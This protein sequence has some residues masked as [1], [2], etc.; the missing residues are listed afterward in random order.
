MT[1]RRRY[2]PA[3]GWD[4]ALP[5]YDPHAKLLGWDAVRSTLLE[6]MA[7]TPGQRV[8]DIGCATGTLLVH[9][10]Q[11]HPDVAVVGLDPDPKALA[12]AAR[13]ALRAGVKVHFNRGFSDQL[14]YA[15]ASFDH[16]SCT[17]MFSLL[18]PAE[19][20]TTLREIRR[21]LRPGGSFHLLDLVKNPPGSS[22][23]VRF[24]PQSARRFHA[25]TED[26]ILALMGQAGLTGA[27]RTRQHPFWLWPLAS[28]RASR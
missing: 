9:L 18:P 3:A 6:Q 17:G 15:N 23:W 8:L 27:R 21:V 25:C 2:F 5:I 10:K 4:W 24:L 19:K 26:E 7:L 22:L 14:P 20:E 28:Y 16:V 13:K 12:R 1:A 11:L